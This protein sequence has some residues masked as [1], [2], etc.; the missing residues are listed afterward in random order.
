MGTLC[1]SQATNHTIDEVAHLKE[2][3]PCDIKNPET[4]AKA[5]EAAVHLQKWFRAILALKYMREGGYVKER[6][7][8][9][10]DLEYID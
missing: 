6:Q 4:V 8:V 2:C 10:E 3:L 7:V 9:D 1:G 5:H